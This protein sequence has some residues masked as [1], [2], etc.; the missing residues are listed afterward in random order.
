MNNFEYLMHQLEADSVAQ[1]VAPTTLIKCLDLTSLNPMHD[2]A[3]IH[4]L[5]L[6]A[7]QHQVAAV[8]IYP[9]FVEQVAN[10]LKGTNI[11]VVAVVKFPQGDQ[12][13]KTIFLTIENALK[14]GALEFE[15]VIP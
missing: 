7:L 12:E 13:N 3:S 9:A 11:K 10:S 14:D 2:E 6:K 8:C 5:C 15:A 4:Q 1:K